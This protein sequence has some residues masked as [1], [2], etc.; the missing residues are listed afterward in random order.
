MYNIID[1]IL[2]LISPHICKSC[3]KVG[4]TLCES[5]IFDITRDKYQKCI[6]CQDTISRTIRDKNGNLCAK[7]RK[8]L[9]FQ[10]V[11]VCGERRGILLDLVGDF[12]YNSERA[13]RKV[14]A[15]IL[16]EAVVVPSDTAVTAIPTA[17]SHIRTRGFDHAKLLAK[18][19]AHQQKLKFIAPL[20]RTTNQSQHDL[21][22]KDRRVLAKKMFKIKKSTNIPEKILLID[23]IWTTGATTISAAQLLEKAGAKEIYLAI[24]A[25]Q[26]G[27][28]WQRNNQKTRNKK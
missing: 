6:N 13:S 2:S 24:I 28:K 11:F 15:K 19:F 8:F 3:G 7:C 18:T 22:A 25:R 20:I 26:V 5:C 21:S 17:A 23:D 10:K 27:E 16:A 14:I 1:Q 12:K 9:P 4:A